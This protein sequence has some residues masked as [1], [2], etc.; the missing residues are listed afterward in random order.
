MKIID[1]LPFADWPHI[2]T[3][4]GDRVDVYRNRIIV[5][6]SIDDL[7]R[8]LPAILDSGLGRN[9]SIGESELRR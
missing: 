7:L 1:R 2:V 3:V 4:R 9:L 8:P 5:W 6:S